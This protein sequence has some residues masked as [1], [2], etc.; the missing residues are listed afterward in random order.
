[1]AR[2]RSQDGGLGGVDVLLVQRSTDVALVALGR[3]ANLA[4][5]AS[6]SSSDSA[7]ISSFF[8]S[9]CLTEHTDSHWD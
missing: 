3:G 5:I 4:A 6:F 8:H 2:S 7:L 9:Y 1:V